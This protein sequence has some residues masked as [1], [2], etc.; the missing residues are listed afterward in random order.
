MIGCRARIALTYKGS[1]WGFHVRN[2][3][4]FRYGGCGWALLVL[5]IAAYT[6]WL[7]IVNCW[8]R[9]PITGDREVDVSLTSYGRRTHEVWKTLETIGRGNER[10][11]RVILWLD[12]EVSVTCPPT[13]LR[14]L[15]RRGLEVRHC[16]DWGPHKKYF[17]YIMQ[18]ECAVTLVTADDDVFYPKHWLSGLLAAHRDGQV[19]A[20]RARIR[21]DSP[22][23]CWPKCGTD[24]PSDRVFA[25]G[26]SGVA[27]PPELLSVLRSRGDAFLSVCPR[28]DDFWLHYAAVANNVPIRQ[29]SAVAKE[30]W[31]HP[32]T[33]RD[34]LWAE[35]LKKGTNDAVSEPA[36]RAWLHGDVQAP[37]RC[38]QPNQCA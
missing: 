7:R 2:V 29:V 21:C 30:W 36:K 19:T 8:S 9:R 1:R 14:R 26:V 27:Y 15:I 17:P 16:P 22:Y 23:S 13:H 28:A 20:Y 37:P 6:W 4:V 33:F 24:Q 11:R 10:P 12:D 18:E 34:G 3:G 38:S 5:Q 32:S 25:T 31:P 35:N